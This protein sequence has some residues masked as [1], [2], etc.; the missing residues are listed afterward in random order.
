MER[1]AADEKN[2]STRIEYQVIARKVLE[3]LVGWF[4]G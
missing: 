2:N 3:R 1:D 4:V